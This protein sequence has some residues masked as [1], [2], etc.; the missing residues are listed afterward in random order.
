MQWNSMKWDTYIVCI[1]YIVCIYI[2]KYYIY[3]HHINIIYIYISVCVCV[4]R[5]AF[6]LRT[7][8]MFLTN[9]KTEWNKQWLSGWSQR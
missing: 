6:T 3:I 4:E 1:L 7:E 5:E 2:N 9:G 8:D